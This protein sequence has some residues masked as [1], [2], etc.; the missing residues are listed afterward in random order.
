MDA[1]YLGGS[2]V[3]RCSQTSIIHREILD[4]KAEKEGGL[5]EG[6]TEAQRCGLVGCAGLVHIQ[7]CVRGVRKSGGQ[8][9]AVSVCPKAETSRS[10]FFFFFLLL[11]KSQREKWK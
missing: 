2:L 4:E 8:F 1:P 11:L 5:L 10:V 3:R 9:P 7:P 6:E